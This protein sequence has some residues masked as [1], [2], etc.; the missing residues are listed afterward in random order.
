MTREKSAEGDKGYDL[1][2]YLKDIGHPGSP[3][4]PEGHCIVKEKM[5]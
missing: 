5:P 1:K 2:Q 4:F 3:L